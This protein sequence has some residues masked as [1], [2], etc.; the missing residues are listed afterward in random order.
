MAALIE[1]PYSRIRKTAERD[2]TGQAEV[3]IFPGERFER[4]DMTLADRMPARGM[5]MTVH[6]RFFDANGE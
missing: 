5:R 6:A 1:F 2:E 4:L 3:I